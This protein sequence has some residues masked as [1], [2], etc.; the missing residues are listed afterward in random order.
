LA[1]AYVVDTLQ[2]VFHYFFSGRDFE[3]CLVNTVNQGG[4]ADTTGAI[5]GMLAGAY[6]GLEGIPLR[7]LKK[8]DRKLLEEISTLSKVLV[9]LSPLGSG[10]G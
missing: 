9:E 8:M 2:T 4:D 1:T 5:V 3:E 10:Q 6:Y 7:W